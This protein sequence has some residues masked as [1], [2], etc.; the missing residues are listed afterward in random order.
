MAVVIQCNFEECGLQEIASIVL[1]GIVMVR[2]IVPVVEQ[3][4][5]NVLGQP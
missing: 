1:K 3:K 4:F 5:F 2:E